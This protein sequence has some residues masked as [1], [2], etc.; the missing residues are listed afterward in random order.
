[1]MYLLKN[2]KPS[3]LLAYP[4]RTNPETD[5]KSEGK[6]VNENVPFE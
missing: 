6:Y 5:S 3:S 2:K 1:M 4:N